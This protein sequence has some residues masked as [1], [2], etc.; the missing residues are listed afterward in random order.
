[1]NGTTDIKCIQ[2]FAHCWICLSTLAGSMAHA[3]C[4]VHFGRKDGFYLGYHIYPDA[5][6]WFDFEFYEIEQ[7]HLQVCGIVSCLYGN[8]SVRHSMRL[9]ITSLS[10][11]QMQQIFTTDPIANIASLLSGPG[12]ANRAAN[13]ASFY[14]WLI[15]G[16]DVPPGR[17]VLEAESFLRH[18]LGVCLIISKRKSMGMRGD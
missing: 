14:C 1:M 13:M 8:S 16:R 6:V 12:P 2:V 15:L 18:G 5:E 7:V 3:F 11:L 10:S 4:L 17:W 9:L